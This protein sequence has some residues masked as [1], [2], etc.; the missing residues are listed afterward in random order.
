MCSALLFLEKKALHAFHVP[1]HRMM[2][3]YVGQEPCSFLETLASVH[4]HFLP[5]MKKEY[6]ATRYSWKGRQIEASLIILLVFFGWRAIYVYIQIKI[7]LQM[8]PANKVLSANQNASS[9]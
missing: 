9:T 1:I 3:T 4:T 6:S 5:E 2:S 8:W 7:F